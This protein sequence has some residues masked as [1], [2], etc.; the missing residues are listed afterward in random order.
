MGNNKTTV[1]KTSLGGAIAVILVFLVG[2][3][4][5]VLSAEES[6]LIVGALCGSPIC[7]VVTGV[8]LGCCG[9]WTAC[10]FCM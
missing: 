5:V 2:K 4:G 1:G 3:I 6:A 7:L 10:C 9:I 8:V